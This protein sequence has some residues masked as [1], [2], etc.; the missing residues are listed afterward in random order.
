MATATATATRRR[1]AY[2]GAV[3][4]G[5]GTVLSWDWQAE[6]FAGSEAEAARNFKWQFKKHIRL[7]PK[8]RVVLSAKPRAI[9]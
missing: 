7:D 1:F 8:A 4:D 2:R 9:S 6:T 5:F 3:K